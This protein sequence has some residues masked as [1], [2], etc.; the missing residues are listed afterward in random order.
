MHR[1]TD[2]TPFPWQAFSLDER[3]GQTFHVFATQR[4]LKAQSDAPL[5][6]SGRDRLKPT[7]NT[8]SGTGTLQRREENRPWEESPTVAGLNPYYGFVVN[9]TRMNI[10]GRQN[11]QVNVDSVSQGMN[12]RRGG[13][14]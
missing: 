9:S 10:S 1:R 12:R 4:R 13:G 3:H 14:A 11:S 5:V 2:T 6:K 7:N 8:R